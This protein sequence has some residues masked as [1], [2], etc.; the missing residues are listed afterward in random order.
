MPNFYRKSKSTAN[1]CELESFILTKLSN[2]L[3]RNTNI[4]NILLN[5]LKEYKNFKFAKVDISNRESLAKSFISLV[6]SSL[7]SCKI[8]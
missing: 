6:T 3:K 5:F 7:T 2:D 4:K 8:L 1:K